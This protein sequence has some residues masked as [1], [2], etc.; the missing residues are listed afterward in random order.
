MKN[1]ET[2]F[3]TVS[4]TP[5]LNRTILT[6]HF[7]LGYHNRAEGTTC[8]TP[9]GSGLNL[10]RAL[11][12]LEVHS[13]VVL[14]VGD[15]M[16]GHNLA[17][18]LEK[19]NLNFTLLEH[20]GQTSHRFIIVD[21]GLN[22]ETQIIEQTTRITYEDLVKAR[23][24][25]SLIP[26]DVVIY[27]GGLPADAPPETYAD[28][29]HASHKTGADVVLMTWGEGLLE[30]LNASP[31]LIHLTQ[32]KAEAM[33]N[34]PVRSIQDVTAVSRLLRERGARTVLISL[35]D[36]EGVVYANQENTWL[37]TIPHQIEGTTTG[38]WEA[39]LA[40]MMA[41]RDAGVEES[42]IKGGQAA[43]YTGSR[44]GNQFADRTQLQSYSHLI[45]LKRIEQLNS[46]AGV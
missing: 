16:T 19:E 14:M 44:L 36:N 45:E 27:A 38:I 43:L 40:G 4:L 46:E 33:L 24:A 21:K 9:G 7:S 17:W 20:S 29:T 11:S 22:T 10:A 42:L 34:D 5:S 32:R 37:V 3:I 15:D 12:Q 13:Q 39:F 1:D 30:A 8:L 31:D 41:Y 25:L 35:D 26:G 28:F 23:Q 2:R 6:H 18:L